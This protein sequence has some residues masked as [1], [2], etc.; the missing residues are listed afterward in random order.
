VPDTNDK[1][2]PVQA[3]AV[4]VDPEAMTVLWMN[5]SAAEGLSAP[6][7]APGASIGQALPLAETM[8]VAEALRMAAETGEAQHLHANLV[9]TA[10][11]SLEIVTSVYRLPD[12]KL[13]VLTDNAWQQAART[14]RDGTTGRSG[15]RSR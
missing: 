5:E 4:L 6:D 12:G 2:T 8:G 3:K 10:R 13:L 15:G 7:S 14:K 11:G 1:S 9:S